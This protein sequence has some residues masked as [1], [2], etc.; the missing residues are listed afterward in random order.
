M[1]D[2]ARQQLTH[3]HAGMRLIAQ[4][5]IFNKGDFD[6]LRQFITDYYAEAALADT[7]LKT[8]LAEQKA[9][10]RLSG[11]LRFDQLIAYGEHEVIVALA[12][13][14]GDQSYMAHMAVTEEYPHKVLLY[15]Q[16]AL[17]AAEFDAEIIT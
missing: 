9:M 8:R 6:R 10:Y 1:D 16:R 2:T 14:R 4:L 5:S 7:A 17:E 12:C 13:E 15:V 3:S 11:K